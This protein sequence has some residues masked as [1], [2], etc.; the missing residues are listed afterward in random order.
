MTYFRK[1]SAPDTY[2]FRQAVLW[3]DKP[4]S[5]VMVSGDDEALHI[6]VFEEEQ[7]VG[8]G[9]FF[10]DLPK[11]RLRK[12]AIASSHRRRGL[13]SELIV[14]ASRM[15][16]REGVTLLWCDARQSAQAFYDALGFD[17]KGEV[18]FK[19]GLPYVI[20]ELPLTGGFDERVK[21]D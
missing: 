16:E 3:P 14:Q 7:L 21:G 13:G 2:D 4:L 10:V 9:S 15:L 19:S 11:A 8:V 12:L 17:I 20:A 5:H 6:G 18:F 1:I